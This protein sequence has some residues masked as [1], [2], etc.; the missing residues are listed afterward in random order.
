MLH[1]RHRTTPVFDDA[2]RL[3]PWEQGHAA[4]QDQALGLELELIE[5]VRRRDD[6]RDAT[7]PEARWL[8]DEILLVTD[9]LDTLVSTMPL[10]G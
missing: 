6:I 7:D 8:D 5:L 9:Q 1:F 4:P 10:A 3:H 2:H